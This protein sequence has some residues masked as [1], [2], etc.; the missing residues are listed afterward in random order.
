MALSESAL[1]RPET[2]HNPEPPMVPLAE[3]A[4]MAG[5]HPEALRSM[6]RRGQLA[7]RRDNRRG[8]LVAAPQPAEQNTQPVNDR[9]LSNLEDALAELREELTGLR[10]A[11]ARSEAGHEAALAQARAE[12]EAR[13]AIATAESTAHA[14]KAEAE[15]AAQRELVTELRK[16][17]DDARRPWWRR[18]VG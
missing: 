3:A 6:I 1:D 16:L 9:P 5:R 7:A 10:E 11:L 12:G 2:D 17:L 13:V 8:W 4:V 14:A 15:A 18:W